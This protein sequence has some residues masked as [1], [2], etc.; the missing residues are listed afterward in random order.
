MARM[1]A[2]IDSTNFAVA[3]GTRVA[4]LATSTRVAMMTT[5]LWVM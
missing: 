2:V 4:A 5:M 3:E 1:S